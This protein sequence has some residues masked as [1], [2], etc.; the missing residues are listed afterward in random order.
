MAGAIPAALCG[1]EGTGVAPTAL[2]SFDARAARAAKFADRGASL[3]VAWAL[4]HGANPSPLLRVTAAPFV[5]YVREIWLSQS[6]ISCERKAALSFPAIVEAFYITSKR[7][8]DS[9][10]TFHRCSGDP[11]A[12][13]M[14]AAAAA[15]WKF[16]AP[17][18]AVDQ[19]GRTL[20]L[21]HA[22]P[23]LA[24]QSIMEALE[25]AAVGR[26]YHAAQARAGMP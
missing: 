12:L 21:R 9:A 20:D 10:P 8:G 26:A 23:Q 24:L 15:G 22:S 17:H 5:R 13:A 2:R 18:L 6:I 19:H 1:A 4:G 7:L 14:R 25:A 3:A 11:V 16:A